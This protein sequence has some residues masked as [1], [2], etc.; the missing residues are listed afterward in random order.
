MS[1]TFDGSHKLQSLIIPVDQGD[2]NTSWVNPF[3][4]GGGADR[5]VF[6]LF[7]GTVGGGATVDVALFQA[8]DAA[9]TG[10]KAITGADLTQI[11]PANDEK[12]ASIE[13]GPGA[14]DDANGFK[15]VRAEVN[16]SA[17][18]IYGVFLIKHRLRYPGI[19]DQHT[20]YDD[21]VIVLG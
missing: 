21:Q 10:R 13:I 16:C 20:S 14:L 7:I 11:T 15:Y 19:G 17:T 9:G 4:D 1:H 3:S 18:E 6:V 8:T 12:L 5:A 2:V